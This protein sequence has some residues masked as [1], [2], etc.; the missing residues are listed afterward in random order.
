M[1]AAAKA[2]K[3]VSEWKR[4]MA[5]ARRE[6]RQ[7]EKQM[8]VTKGREA[9]QLLK[10]RFDYPIFLYDGQHVGITATGEQ[11]VCELYHSE[12]LGLPAGVK[13]EDTALE[14]YC[15]FKNN[16]EAFVLDSGNAGGKA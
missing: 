11:D 6:L 13:P 15:R 5:E 1:C 9:R 4:R 2:A 7:Y 3:G 8:A 16:A 12:T 10:E 14:Q